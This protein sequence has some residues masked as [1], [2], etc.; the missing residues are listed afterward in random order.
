MVGFKD[1]MQGFLDIILGSDGGGGG[2]LDKMNC[3]FIGS[4]LERLRKTMCVG[5]IP[6]IYQ[7]TICLILCGVGSMAAALATFCINR[8]WSMIEKIEQL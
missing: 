1:D 5:L 2:L 3:L 4:N 6:N 7:M 8:R